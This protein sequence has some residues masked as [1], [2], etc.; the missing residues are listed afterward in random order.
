MEK[1]YGRYE[2]EKVS[3][4]VMARNKVT[5]RDIA[6]ACGVSVATVSYVLN[7]SKKE[8]ICHE[9]RLKIVQTAAAMHYVPA[10]L[11]NKQAKRKSNLI[12]III[13]LKE[14]NSVGKKMQYYDL[15]VELSSLIRKL[16]FE[17]LLIPT[18]NMEKD[19]QGIAAL[20]LDAIFIIDA[21]SST[22]RKVTRN[23]Y[24]PVIFLDCEVNDTLFC[25]IYP[26]YPGLFLKAKQMLQTDSPFLLMEDICNQDLKEWITRNFQAKDVFINEPG[27]DLKLFLQIHT[28]K[29]GIVLGDYLGMQAQC[30]FGSENLVVVSSLECNHILPETSSIFIRNRNK[31]SVAVETLKD[32]LYL[33]YE[34]K[35]E[36]RIL[37]GYELW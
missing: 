2:N 7:H 12:G 3:D 8:K 23:Y 24:V 32:M 1:K 19:V 20:N 6:E 21:D 33:D 26:D 11:S 18:T 34:P 5:M 31:A 16:G 28:S 25:K 27:R 15:A 37:L 9:T 29:K 35:E 22:A 13:N 30:L 17:A 14:T 10:V 36:N 4:I